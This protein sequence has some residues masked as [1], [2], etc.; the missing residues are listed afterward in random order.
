VVGVAKDTT[1]DRKDKDLRQKRQYHEV[2]E[3]AKL[4]A[5]QKLTAYF[6]HE[7]RNPL[8]ALDSALNAVPDALPNEM[9]SLVSEMQSCIKLM[10]SI[11][12]NLIDVRK[13]EEGKVVLTSAPLSLCCLLSEVHKILLPSVKPG[14]TFQVISNTK[15]RDWVLGDSVR[16]RQI[17]TNVAAN[18]IKYTLSGTVT[19]KLGWDDNVVAFTC[20]DTG[21][22]PPQV[23]SPKQVPQQSMYR[24]G[25]PSTGLD[26]AVAKH[27]VKLAGGTI[28]FHNSPT[29]ASSDFVGISCV[30]HLPLATCESSLSS[31][32]NMNIQRIEAPLRFLVADDI[33]MNRTMLKRRL[34]N[35]ICPT[36]IVAEAS[37][38]E[39]A[40][41][42]CGNENFDVIIVDQYMEEA[43]GVMVG[44]DVIYTL[45]RMGVNSI[46]IGCSGNDLDEEFTDAGVD[47]VWQKPIPSND[48]III[49]IRRA[50]A[51]KQKL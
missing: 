39:E 20:D 10:S 23:S 22:G 4:E 16:L 2:I 7:L 1:N 19:L 11:M 14:V 43:G 45:R 13:L 9:K 24:C 51:E 25:A 42:M 28:I 26:L 30:V 35:S 12:S 49:Q 40:L 38:G 37:T 46:I 47:M 29:A 15:E 27:L 50:I 5:E 31:V 36:C 18:A 3:E 44:T 34:Q 41:V 8:S 6:A 32:A 48:E 17:L 33:K 21:P